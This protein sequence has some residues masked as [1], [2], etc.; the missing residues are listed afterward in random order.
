M[1]IRKKRVGR[2]PGSGKKSRPAKPAE[3]T[4][5]KRRGR[6]PKSE[7]EKAKDKCPGQNAAADVVEELSPLEYMISVINDP[8][9]SAERRDKMAIE[10]AKYCHANGIGMQRLGKKQIGQMR[11]EE[12]AKSGKYA[13]PPAPF[14]VVDS[15][16]K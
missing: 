4:K 15:G 12:A 6:P 2:P 8:T 3:E 9:A 14:T 16:K 1:T 5:K 10:A 13:T 11:A 7:S